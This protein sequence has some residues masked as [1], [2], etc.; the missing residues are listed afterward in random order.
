MTKLEKFPRAVNIEI[1][2]TNMII[3]NGII[4]PPIIRKYL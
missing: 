1:P 4:E 3:D 2:K